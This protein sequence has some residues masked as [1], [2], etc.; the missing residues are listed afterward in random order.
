MAASAFVLHNSGKELVG[1]G[2][3]DLDVTTA[4]TFKCA[5]FLTGADAHTATVATVTGITGTEVT[6]TGYTAG[7]FDVSAGVTWVESGGT[8]TWDCSD[9]VWTATGS[10]IVAKYAVV[11][12]VASDAILCSTDLD[13]GGGSV[14]ATDGNTFTVAMNGSGVFTKT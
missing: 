7:G 8:V 5:L 14:T 6:N 12:D 10:D 11:Y 2:T 4:A 3:I 9:A 1:D 13:D